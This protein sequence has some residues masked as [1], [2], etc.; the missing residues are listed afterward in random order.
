MNDGR[1]DEDVRERER[2]MGEC[3][4]LV[5]ALLSNSN[6]LENNQAVSPKVGRVCVAHWLGLTLRDSYSSVR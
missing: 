4:Q 2:C 6:T 1:E 5:V 3:F